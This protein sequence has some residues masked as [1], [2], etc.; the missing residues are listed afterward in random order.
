MTVRRATQDDL[1]LV[2]GLG[3]DFHAASPHSVDPV[4]PKG[5]RDFASRLIDHGAVFV[6]DGGMIGGA[7]APVYF[8]PA[9]Q[10][11]YELF[12]WSPDHKGRAL[13]AAF[14]Q[15]ARDAGAKGIQWTAIHNDHLP[16]VA[17]V[18]ERAGATPTEVAFRE[19][20]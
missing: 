6:T 5:W 11:A 1:D 3:L 19:R 16:R 10:Y 7:L 14:R 4:D 15:W 13:M 8:N 12:W 17:A 9:I 18:Y 2:V 20:F